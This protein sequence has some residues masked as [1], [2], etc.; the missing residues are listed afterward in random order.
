MSRDI[1]ILIWILHIYQII[2]DARRNMALAMA[3]HTL[4]YPFSP[5]I[6]VGNLNHKLVLVFC[7]PS[8]QTDSSQNLSSNSHQMN[9]QTIGNSEALSRSVGSLSAED[10]EGFYPCCRNSFLN[11]KCK[12]YMMKMD[13]LSQIHHH[14]FPCNLIFQNAQ[15]IYDGFYMTY[16]LLGFDWI[17][18]NGHLYF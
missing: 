9:N 16:E 10:S 12:V 3:I 14:A 8:C 15:M 6:S 7:V 13:S 2:N 18:I 1:F 11:S 17:E 4:S 5:T